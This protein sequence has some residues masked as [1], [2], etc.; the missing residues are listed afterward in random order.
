MCRH[1]NLPDSA[2]A[3]RCPSD[4]LVPFIFSRIKIPKSQRA[5][6]FHMRLNLNRLWEAEKQSLLKCDSVCWSLPKL[7]WT[8]LTSPISVRGSLSSQGSRPK[9]ICVS[10]GSL[11]VNVRPKLVQARVPRT[12]AGHAGTEMLSLLGMWTRTPT[13]SRPPCHQKIAGDSQLHGQQSRDSERNQVCFDILKPL[14]WTSLETKPTT[15]C[16]WLH[17][18]N[19][20]LLLFKLSWIEVSGLHNPNIINLDQ[21]HLWLRALMGNGVG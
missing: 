2:E 14:D 7:P 3:R 6:P 17:G 12:F 9:Q 8:K 10:R 18:A 20:F 15:G 16:F 13:L 4:W 11:G 1:E 21:P 5:D 19:K